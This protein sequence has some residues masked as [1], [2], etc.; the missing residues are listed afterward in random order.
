MPH[1]QGR[2]IVIPARDCDATSKAIGP[3]EMAFFVVAAL[4]VIAISWVHLFHPVNIVSY[5]RDV[6]HHTAVLNA[7]L[8]SPFHASN[9]HVVSDAPSRSYMP[10]YVGLALLGRSFGLDPQQLLGISAAL[11]ITVLLLGVFLFARAY[12]NHRWAPLI[13][14]LIMFGSW[15]GSF[16]HTGFH[17]FSTMV[18]SA[19]YPFAIVFGAGF[20]AWWVVLKT[21]RSPKPSFFILGAIAAMTAFMFATHQLQGAFSIG[22]MLSFALFHGKRGYAR[23]GLIIAFVLVGLL[24]SSLWPYYNPLSYASVG[25]FYTYLFNSPIDWTKPLVVLAI[26]GFSPI[27]VF[28]FYDI[29]ERAWRLDLLFGTAGILAGLV[30]LYLAGSWMALRFLPLIVV[31]L[32]LSTTALVLD[33]LDRKRGGLQT[34]AMSVMICAIFGMFLWNAGRAVGTTLNVEQYLAGEHDRGFDGWSPN[35]NATAAT[36]RGIVGDGRVVIADWTTA[37]PIQAYFMKV[38]SIPYPFSEVPDS[39]I[40]QEASK[41]FFAADTDMTRRCAI[42]REYD[43]A[44]IVYRRAKVSADIQPAIN[45]LGDRVDVNDLTVVR[46]PASGLE[47]CRTP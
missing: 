33:L 24:L 5:D 37:Y 36:V 12:F 17:T 7:L 27:G 15:A 10:W 19:S 16:N 23:R 25:G 38:V 31:F 21:L 28:G 44:A 47:L 42:L 14:L 32:Q 26:L 20:I 29:R 3:A 41:A 22:G 43:V 46:L 45:A 6:W 35:I 39:A 1:D 13:L 9:P 18:F 4:I 34:A 11:S 2:L 40:R 30:V 8:D